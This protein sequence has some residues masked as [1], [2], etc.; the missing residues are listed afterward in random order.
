MNSA[1]TYSKTEKGRVE[2]AG[3]SGALDV[4]QRRLL[5][6]IDGT[7]TDKELAVFV[8]AG[9]LDEALD[10]LLQD[11]LIE[12]S[13]EVSPM[14]AQAAPA[15]A[16]TAA[17]EAHR[18]AT[19]PEEF[20]QVRQQA[21]DFVRE[22]LGSAGEP[23]CDAMGRCQNLAELRKVLRGVEIFVGQRLGARTGQAFARQFDSIF[24]S[25]QER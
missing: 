20:N 12:S 18:P 10:Y 25:G 5:I 11:G 1:M 22:R 4:V 21:L 2:L 17:N 3:R 9:E 24:P 13:A 14:L 19:S 16:A 7:K 23:I 8:R 15:T 6:L